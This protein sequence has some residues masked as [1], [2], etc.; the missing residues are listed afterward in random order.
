MKVDVLSNTDGVDRATD[1]IWNETRVNSNRTPGCVHY[2]PQTQSLSDFSD[3]WTFPILIFVLFMPTP[4]V[5]RRQCIH[6]TYKAALKT[7]H[8]FSTFHCFSTT[9]KIWFSKKR[10]QSR[11][12]SHLQDT[13]PGTVV[14]FFECSDILI[15]HARIRIALKIFCLTGVEQKACNLVPIG[16]TIVRQFTCIP[17]LYILKEQLRIFDSTTNISSFW[18]HILWETLKRSGVL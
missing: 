14:D 7:R 8:F 12:C 11:I 6:S 2:Y 13:I 9:L 5:R 4:L 16:I 3:Q 17:S 18:N 1:W 10:W 15:F